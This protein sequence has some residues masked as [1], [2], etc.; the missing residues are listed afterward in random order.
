MLP[1]GGCRVLLLLPMARVAVPRSFGAARR[2][3]NG[4][5]TRSEGAAGEE[6]DVDA[7]MCDARRCCIVVMIGDV[8]VRNVSRGA[9]ET[10]VTGLS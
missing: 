10:G 5:G 8:S 6:Q 9:G 7:A 2:E 4:S 1:T 3:R